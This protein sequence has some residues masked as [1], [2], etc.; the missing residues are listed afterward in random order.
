LLPRIGGVIRAAADTLP[1]DAASLRAL[2][3][4]AWAERDT[5]IA[6]RDAAAA[7]RDAASAQNDRLRHLLL[8]LRR[9]QFGTKSERLPEAQLQLGLEDLEAAIAK[10]DA[11]AEERDP[12]LRRE[13]AAKR[14]AS[15]GA[16]PAHLPRIEVVLEP[17][18]TACPCC[19]GEMAVIGED[20]S[21]RLD[22]ILSTGVENWPDVGVENSP[23][24]FG[25]VASVASGRLDGGQVAEVEF[26]DGLE[27]LCRWGFAEAVGQSVGPSGVFRLQGKQFGDGIVPALWS[28][29]AIGWSAI[30]DDRCRL[31]LLAA[32]AVFGLPF[33]VGE[34]RCGIRLAV[35]WHLPSSPVT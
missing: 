24:C 9:M 6:E 1:E 34:R 11:E 26:D 35:Y 5:A 16:L 17:E 7:E 25:L 22:V 33:G 28:A 27:G 4:T 13:G 23:L 10:G 20:R 19:Q 3:L 15:R 32:G 18:D 29:A 21:E 14:R 31:Q 8:K 30:A 12:A 2:L